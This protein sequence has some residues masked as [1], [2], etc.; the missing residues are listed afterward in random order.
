M[1]NVDGVD[2]IATKQ[3]PPKAFYTHKSKQSGLRY[4]LASSIEGGD[5]VHITSPLPPG[6]WNDL[7]IFRFSVKGLLD[8]GE[9]A[10]ADA[11]YAFQLALPARKVSIATDTTPAA[12][13]AAD[14]RAVQLC[15][16]EPSAG[17]DILAHHA[18]YDAFAGALYP[19]YGYAADYFGA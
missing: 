6:D 17:G 5:I 12:K 16:S 10:E 3:G 14:F 4:E 15:K 9:R 2:C 7:M 11:G 13:K 19:T 8:D 18:Q 1:V